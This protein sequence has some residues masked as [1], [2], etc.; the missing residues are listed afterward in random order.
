MLGQCFPRLVVPCVD[1]L[2]FDS[3]E[4][5]VGVCTSYCL[6]MELGTHSLRG[7]TLV[8][9]LAAVR[10]SCKHPSEQSIFS[11]WVTTDDAMRMR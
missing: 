8:R 6:Q 3:A 9:V 4:L 5:V 11:V 2:V 10:R 7:P 1:C